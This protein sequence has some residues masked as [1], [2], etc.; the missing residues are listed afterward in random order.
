MDAVHTMGANFPHLFLSGP[1][2]NSGHLSETYPKHG[3]NRHWSR[4][5]H[6][7]GAFHVDKVQQNASPPPTPSEHSLFGNGEGVVARCVL[8]AQL[9]CQVCRLWPQFC[10]PLEKLSKQTRINPNPFPT[11]QTT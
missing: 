4:L 6:L 10:P 1:G 5:R 8:G 9:L 7:L 2:I 11:K 3:R